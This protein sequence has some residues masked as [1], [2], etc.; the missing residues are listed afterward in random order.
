MQCL[1]HSDGHELERAELLQSSV[2]EVAGE[3]AAVA[4]AVAPAPAPAPDDAPAPAAKKP[5][6]LQL[7][8][9]VPG[10]KSI[11]GFLTVAE[12]EV[13]FAYAKAVTDGCIVEVGIAPAGFD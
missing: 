13:L 10:F 5:V 11:D 8:D 1:F 4:A 9:A 2:T 12:G 7:T 6:K 3:A